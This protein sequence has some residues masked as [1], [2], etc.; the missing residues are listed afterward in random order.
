MW[1][2]GRSAKARVEEALADQ[3]LT[4]KLGLRVDVK[5]KV[6]HVSGSVPNERYKNLIKA[7]ATGINGIDDVDLT[8]V[9][10]EG[11]EATGTTGTMGTGTGTIGGTASADALDAPSA[12][13][14]EAYAKIRAD[15]SLA[16]NP[17]DVLQKGNVVVLRG[18][19]DSAEELERAKTLAKSV[20]GVTDVDV[21]GLQVIEHAS[22]LNVTDDDGDVVYT[23]QS[24]DTLSHIALHYYGSAGRSSYMKI[25]EAN[26]LADANKIF[27]GQKLKIPGTTKG[28]DEVLA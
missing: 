19:V 1:P 26:G 11:T 2:F 23:V 27:V 18:A 9:K 5:K 12:R 21:S 13:A 22:E 15:S 24:G 8:N 10:V 28:P 3:E 4:A 7:V 25:A 17:L 20:Q 14:K 16:N 6:A